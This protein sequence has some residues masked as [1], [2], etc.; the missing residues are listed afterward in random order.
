MKLPDGS[1]G[2]SYE[3]CIYTE[4]AN[5]QLVPVL[6]TY[7]DDYFCSN[8]SSTSHDSFQKAAMPHH[9]DTYIYTFFLSLFVVGLNSSSIH[10]ADGGTASMTNLISDRP[11]SG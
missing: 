9:E 6:P 2:F 4:G 7:L 10:K 3:N 8:A 1:G 5:D 11:P